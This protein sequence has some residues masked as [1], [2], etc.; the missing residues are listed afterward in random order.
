MLTVAF[1]AIAFVLFALVGVFAW[2][3]K[4]Q[5]RRGQSGSPNTAG[6]AKQGRAVGPN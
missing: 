5:N 1:I 2:M 6:S 3:A 4:D